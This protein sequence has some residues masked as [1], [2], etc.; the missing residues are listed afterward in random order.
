MLASAWERCFQRRLPTILRSLRKSA[1][2]VL[3]QFH[4]EA[5]RRAKERGLGLPRITM[6]A[7][8][9]EAYTAIFQ[10]LCEAAVTLLNDGQK[11]INRAFTP[12]I[13]A[14]MDPAYTICSDERGKGSFA[15][16]KGHMTTHV[17]GCQDVMFKTASEE[18]RAKL[19]QLCKTIRE[20]LLEKTDQVFVSMSRDYMVRMP[21]SDVCCCLT[22]RLFL[23]S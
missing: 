12:I 3:R 11:D 13:M 8:Q 20:N 18:V 17:Q 22:N 15:R 4:A 7:G 9:L 19:L 10:D 21:R 14:A 16:M 23:G 2:T 6:L 1:S 5:E